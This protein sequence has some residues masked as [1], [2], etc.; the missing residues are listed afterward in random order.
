MRAFLGTLQWF[1]LLQRC[2]L[3]VYQ[4]VYDFARR[5]DEWTV[6]DV[7][8]SVITELIC[9]IMLAPYWAFDMTTPHLDLVGATDAAH[10]FGYGAAI[11]P[12]SI[13]EIRKIARLDTKVWDH[14]T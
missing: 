11:A 4:D 13:E 14:V 12:L 9:G 7:P 5:N 3:A 2:K 1:D 10:E 6:V 8:A